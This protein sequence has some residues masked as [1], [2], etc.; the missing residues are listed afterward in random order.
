MKKGGF[1]T[2]QVHAG[3]VREP[4]DCLPT[5]TPIYPTTTFHYQPADELYRVFRAERKGYSYGRYGTPTH[6]ALE[7]AVAE[8]EGTETALSCASGMAAIHLGLLAAGACAE[9]GVVS[10]RDVYGATYTLVTGL[11]PRLGVPTMTAD[12]SDLESLRQIMNEICPSVIIF[13]TI[14]NPLMKVA[15]LPAVVKIAHQA[16]VR[17]VV[18]NTFATPYLIRPMEHGADFVAHSTTKYIGGHGDVVGGVLCMSEEDREAAFG[19]AIQLGAVLGPQEAWLT[20]RGIRTLSLR[21]ER[22][23]RTAADLAKRLEGHPSVERVNYPGLSSHPDHSVAARL[24]DGGL[25]GGMISFEIKD[26]TPQR[27]FRFM[28]ALEMILPATTL[29]DIYTLVLY[30][31]QSSHKRLTPEQRAAVGIGDGLIRLS[32]GIEDADDIWEDLDRALQKAL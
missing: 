18:D 13:E 8:L 2:R 25:F 17:V 1:T 23:C 11:L 5:V 4:L 21:M 31:A 22:H 14:S 12:F 30:P 27:T 16:G 29:G 7:T 32:V 20:L 24:F 10:A 19:I 9:K 15:D 3:K 26:G 28:N 6:T